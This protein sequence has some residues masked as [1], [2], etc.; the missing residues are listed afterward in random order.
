MVTNLMAIM[1]QRSSLEELEGIETAVAFRT[2]LD[3]VINDS[4]A[5]VSTFT[6]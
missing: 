6:N 1:K 3:S 2:L 4:C 5:Y